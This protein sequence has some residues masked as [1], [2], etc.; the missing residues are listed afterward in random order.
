[1]SLLMGYMWHW[2]TVHVSIQH[3]PKHGRLVCIVFKILPFIYHV[4]HLCNTST[5]FEMF[6]ASFV[7]TQ[8]VND[9]K[10]CEMLRKLMLQCFKISLGSTAN[11]M[12]I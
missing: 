9:K 10:V 6:V 4:A 8:E 7:C 3:K 1:M 2:E 5:Y 12:R 11:R